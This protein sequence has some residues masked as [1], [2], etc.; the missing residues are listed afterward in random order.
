MLI[1]SD[2][3]ITSIEIK[4]IYIPDRKNP[5]SLLSRNAN[6]TGVK[7]LNTVILKL[8][9]KDTPEYLTPNGKLSIRLENTTDEIREVVIEALI[10][11]IKTLITLVEN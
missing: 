9:E 2:K 11:K 1:T 6:T 5:F 10:I 3:I 8:K 7:L 4:S